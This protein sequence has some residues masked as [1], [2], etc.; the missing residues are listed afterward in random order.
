MK[1]YASARLLREIDG[2]RKGPDGLNGDYFL[3]AQDFDKDWATNISVSTP[4]R[5]GKRAT[6]VVELKGKE[7]GTRKL[8]VALV[9]EQNEWKVDKVEGVR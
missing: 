7:M 4:V 5:K 6:T 3:D 2:M 8:R 1:R 9:Q